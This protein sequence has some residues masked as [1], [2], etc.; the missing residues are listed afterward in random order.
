MASKR[1]KQKALTAVQSTAVDVDFARRWLVGLRSVLVEGPNESRQRLGLS[2][3]FTLD[4]ARET[5]DN[6]AGDFDH[7]IAVLA[8]DNKLAFTPTAGIA[9]TLIRL[10]IPAARPSLVSTW[11]S[12]LTAIWAYELDMVEVQTLGIYEAKKSLGQKSLPPRRFKGSAVARRP[13]LASGLSRGPLPAW[14]T[15]SKKPKAN[16]D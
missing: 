16:E 3:F 8:I 10:A 15:P 14:S 11:G 12:L 1:A 9:A 2:Q 13:G 7:A 6:R 5:W 4:R